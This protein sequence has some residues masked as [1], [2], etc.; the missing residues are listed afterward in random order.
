MDRKEEGQPKVK[1]RH[2]QIRREGEVAAKAMNFVTDLLKSKFPIYGQILEKVIDSSTQEENNSTRPSKLFERRVADIM[3]KVLLRSFPTVGNSLYFDIDL[4]TKSGQALN[5]GAGRCVPRGIDIPENRK[6]EGFGNGTPPDADYL[7]SLQ[8][9][10]DKTRSTI[11]AGDFKI[12]AR[13]IK[14]KNNQFKAI[15]NHA[16]NYGSYLVMYITLKGGRAEIQP[17]AKL[18]GRGVRVFVFSLLD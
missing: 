9:P 5:N 16:E 13:D 4:I 18:L 14:S 17:K 8:P 10:A 3:C 2:L 1:K 11:L 7:I 15:G 6:K 12:K